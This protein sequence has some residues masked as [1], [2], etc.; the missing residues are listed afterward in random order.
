VIVKIRKIDIPEYTTAGKTRAD[1]QTKV[2]E[3]E[4][5]SESMRD[6]DKLNL[7]YVVKVVSVIL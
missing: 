2:G 1:I 5:L 7:D 6:R 3:I 4:Q